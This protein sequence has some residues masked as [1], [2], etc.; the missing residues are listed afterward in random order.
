MSSSL[1][2]LAWSSPPLTSLFQT[3][4]TDSAGWS[5]YCVP[6][7]FMLGSQPQLSSSRGQ[8]LLE[9]VRSCGWSPRDEVGASCRGDPTE[10]L[11]PVHAHG[12][13]PVTQCRSCDLAPLYVVLPV[14]LHTTFR[15]SLAGSTKDLAG[16]LIE[17][18]LNYR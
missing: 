18:V 1:S 2:C 12:C 6:R 13:L 9:A 8:G 16:I 7:I 10:L 5:E 3:Q 17:I 14:T 11:S 4:L 15:I